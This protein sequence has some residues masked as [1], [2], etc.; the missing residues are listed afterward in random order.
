MG[1]KLKKGLSIMLV[2]ALC[3]ML[4]VG[5]GSSGQGSKDSTNDP[6]QPTSGKGTEGTANEQGEALEEITITFFDK[7][8]GEAFDDPVAQEIM[9]KTGVKVEIQ[10]PTGDPTEKLG[11][12]L[13]SGDLPDVVLMDRTG[14]TVN[15]YIAAKALIPL[16]DL[17]DEYGP[18]IKAMYGDVLNK[19][20]HS[21]GLNYYLNNWYGPDDE[22]VW[23]M[24]MRMDILKELVGEEKATSGDP[25]STEEFIGLLKQFKEQYPQLEGRDS[26]PFTL[27]GEALNGHSVGVFTSMWGIETYYIN[28]GKVQLPIRDPNYYEALKYMNRLHREGL[29]DR[30]WA[31]SKTELWKQKLAGGY[32][33]ATTGA[34]W[35]PG[36]ANTALK[37]AN[38]G[39]VDSQFYGFKVLPEGVPEDGTT[40]GARSSLGWDAIG[41]TKNN[42]HPERTMQFINYLASEEGQYLL[43][44]G[45]EGEHYTIE[46]GKRVPKPE[47]LQAFK[48]DFGET[49][50][51]TGIR[52]WTWFIKNGPGS[53]GTPYMMTSLNTDE[54][55]AFARL[56]LRDTYYDTADLSG[57][58]PD[59]STAEA[60]VKQKIDDIKNLAIPKIIIAE[61]ESE[62]EELFNAMLTDIEKA[63]EEQLMNVIQEKYD[64][65]QE[66]WK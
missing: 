23:G 54:V 36:D 3:F 11:L 26:I 62:F 45:P 1:H 10:Q 42:K 63:G 37:E 39:D 5:C 47:I 48:D 55:G 27:N 65:R 49:S 31:V 24:L 44:W 9:K 61:S 41:I 20:R 22:P 58:E 33:F 25:F 43:L 13:A 6:D 59:G 38:N 30:D 34:Y 16:N 8:T 64:A 19:S 60:I 53:D 66:L 50:K 28:D 56:S 2:T 12:M 29:I 14:D 7:N 15:K 4:L 21:D 40:L 51:E 18:D 35:D 32:T 57:L 52:K 17:I 46:D